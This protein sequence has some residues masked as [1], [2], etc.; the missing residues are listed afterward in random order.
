MALTILEAYKNYLAQGDVIAA[1]IIKIYAEESD[2][3]LNLPLKDIPGNT[4]KYDQEQALPGVAFRGINEGYT[5]STGVLNPQIESLTIAG[6]DLDVDKF[7]VDTMG[8]Q[9]RAVQESLKAKALAHKISN[10]FIKGD[11]IANPKEF[12]GLQVRLGGNQLIAAG[13]TSGGDALSLAI[14]DQAI[15]AVDNPTHILMSKA[16]RRLLTTAAR[17]YTIGGFITYDVDAFGRKITKYNDLPILIADKNSD[18]YATLAFNEANPG[19]GSAVG[20]S[21]YVC[22][23]GDNMLEGMQ[24]GEMSVRDLGELQTKPVFRTRVEWYMGL[25]LEHPRAAA[26]LYGIKNAAVVV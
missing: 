20:T 3:L 9:Q 19:G 14:L 25:V 8:E 11:S 4:Y 16:V 13:G 21:V 15:D 2:I 22:S 23:F 17:N 6:G 7:I 1:S 18:V 12:D 24:N 5:E 10:T 26:R